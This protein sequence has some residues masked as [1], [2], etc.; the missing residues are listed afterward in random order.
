M[1]LDLLPNNDN[2]SKIIGRVGVLSLSH[3]DG[4]TEPG[5]NRDSA[6]RTAQAGRRRQ[7]RKPEQ[8]GWD[9]KG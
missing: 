4:G 5:F 8:K 2:K 3:P 9:R 1:I 7:D 6:A